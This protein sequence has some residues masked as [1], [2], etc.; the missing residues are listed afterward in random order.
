MSDLFNRD[1]TLTMGAVSLDIQTRNPIFPDRIAPALRVSFDIEK[2]SNRDPNKA[3]VTIYNLNPANRALLQK[4]SDLITTFK[5]LKKLY[6]WQVTIEAGYVGSKS[7]LFVGDITFADSRRDGSDWITTIEAGD[8]QRNYNSRFVSKS[9]GSGTSLFSILVFLVTELGIGFGDSI[10]KFTVPLR[11]LVVFKKGVVLEG[12]VSEILDKYVTSAGYQWSIQ[13]GVL[14]VLAPGET[15][16]E[17]AVNLT[18]SSGLLGSPEKGEDGTVKAVSLLQ[19]ALKPGR[20]VR[21]ASQMVFGNFKI[22]RVVHHGDTWG[23]DW[24]TEVEAQPVRFG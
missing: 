9:F 24:Y 21:I 22:E 6:E 1:L 5:Q 23:T 11:G 10:N 16:F 3:L 14:Q 15:T 17:T 19:G 12:K 13:D 2:T 8:E 20:Q 4:G 18:S 7:K